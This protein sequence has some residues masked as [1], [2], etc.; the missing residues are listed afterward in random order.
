LATVA[1]RDGGSAVCRPRKRQ[2]F[3]RLPIREIIVF[4]LAIC[5]ADLPFTYAMTLNIG[6]PIK[7]YE[8]MLPLLCFFLVGHVC[9]SDRLPFRMKK[10]DRQVAVTVVLFCLFYTVSY[11]FGLPRIAGQ[12]STLPEWFAG[13][14]NPYLASSLRVVQV[15]GNAILFV[16]I[17]VYERGRLPLFIRAWLIGACLSAF[18]TWYSI[19][20]SLSGH[21]PILLPG[22][23]GDLSESLI[24]GALGRTIPRSG[25]FLEGNFAGPYML[26]SALLA[27]SLHSIQKRWYLPCIAWFLWATVFLTFSTIPIV[28]A[29]VI[30]IVVSAMKL[31]H[32]KP[33][34]KRMLLVYVAV[35]LL[36]IGCTQL[37][38]APIIKEVVAYKVFGPPDDNPVIALS[39]AERRDFIQAGFRIFREFPVL[40]VGPS[41]YGLFFEKYSEVAG[42]GFGRKM[43]A[44]NVYVELLA[45]AGVVGLVA[46]LIFGFLII[47]RFLRDSRG[48]RLGLFIGFGFVSLFLM[49][50]AFPT[51]A[52]AYVWVFFAFGTLFPS[53]QAKDLPRV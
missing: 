41:N 34:E 14:F 27:F 2:S 9:F 42:L 20:S 5:I 15:V 10:A 33:I 35:V 25:T 53:V 11:L 39:M 16:M 23:T 12:M 7:I 47:G 4:L 26:L 50:N 24:I 18:Y 30:P 44:N 21:E 40:G 52:V 6:V 37:F 17:I 31:R 49:F 29:L 36:I 51:F 45:E 13:R 43:I 1:S 46:F 48:E 8:A 19:G 3:G 28:C 22:M 32:L 38:S